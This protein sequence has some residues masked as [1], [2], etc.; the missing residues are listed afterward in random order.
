[1]NANKNCIRQSVNFRKLITL[2]TEGGGTVGLQYFLPQLLL[3][4]DIDTER[5]R[6]TG[7]CYNIVGASVAYVCNVIKSNR[8]AAKIE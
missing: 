7:I 8:L 6:L 3:S 2:I 1:M 5:F 4:S